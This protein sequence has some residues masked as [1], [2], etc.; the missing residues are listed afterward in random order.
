[1]TN[2]LDLSR[3]EHVLNNYLGNASLTPSQTGYKWGQES[4]ETEL[5]LKIGR[6]ETRAPESLSVFSTHVPADI[7]CKK[8]C[9]LNK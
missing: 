7:W 5:V 8:N 4:R 2:N 6:Y 1:M 9:N 3:N